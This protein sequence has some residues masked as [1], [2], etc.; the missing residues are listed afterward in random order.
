ML[1]CTVWLHHL[2]RLLLDCFV[3]GSFYFSC[4]KCT[5]VS[6]NYCFVSRRHYV[7]LRREHVI[8]WNRGCGSM[9]SYEFNV[10][11]LGQLTMFAT[12]SFDDTHCLINIASSSS[13]ARTSREYANHFKRKS[14][15]IPIKI[16]C[17]FFFSLFFFFLYLFFFGIVVVII[18]VVMET[19]LTHC[20]LLIAHS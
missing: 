18:V 6:L 20:S 17:L 10:D 4:L 16:C 13:G 15:S 7:V 5:I 12:H 19:F 8:G 9:S 1:A 2:I 3:F 14:S 11:T